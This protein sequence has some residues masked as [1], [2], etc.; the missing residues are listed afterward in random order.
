MIDEE[1]STLIT[2]CEQQSRQRLSDHRSELDLLAA[3]LLDQESLVGSEIEQLLG[4]TQ[5]PA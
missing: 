5:R 4:N 1:V 2:H 3:T